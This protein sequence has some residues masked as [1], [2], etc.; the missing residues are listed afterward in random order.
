MQVAG[1]VVIVT[2]ASGGIGLA[3]ARLL[4]TRGAHVVLA[5]RSAPALQAAAAA[6]PRSINPSFAPAKLILMIWA[7]CAMA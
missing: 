2:G 4:G 7:P 1:K 6:I 5:A 3:T